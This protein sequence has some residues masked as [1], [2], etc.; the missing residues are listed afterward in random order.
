M[1]LLT[2][3]KFGSTLSTVCSELQSLLQSLNSISCQLYCSFT[4]FIICVLSFWPQFPFQQHSVFSLGPKIY[5]VIPSSNRFSDLAF[6]LSI[7]DAFLWGVSLLVCLKPSVV[8]NSPKDPRE[9]W[10]RLIAG[11]RTKGLNPCRQPTYLLLLPSCVTLCKLHKLFESSF[12]YLHMEVEVVTIINH[13]IEAQYQHCSRRV[14]L[15][16]FL[17]NVQQQQS[18][19]PF[20]Y[21]WFVFM[22]EPPH[23]T[24]L[25]PVS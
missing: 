17:L 16:T 4:V 2:I 6:R 7:P 24:S 13:L 9:A 14:K 25:A 11:S 19:V 15:C 5:M 18:M 20:P 1:R 23:P 12:L 22:K 10:E 3:P 21:I 8:P